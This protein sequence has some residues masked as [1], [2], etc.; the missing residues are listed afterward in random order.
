M[1]FH[2]GFISNIGANTNDFGVEFDRNDK[3]AVIDEM[4]INVVQKL[5]SADSGHTENEFENM[6][7]YATFFPHSVNEVS[8]TSEALSKRNHNRHDDGWRTLE[9]ISNQTDYSCNPKS[10]VNSS[11]T[12]KIYSEDE[13]LNGTI[14]LTGP[15]YSESELLDYTD[16]PNESEAAENIALC[17]QNKTI[18]IERDANGNG[19]DNISYV[20]GNIIDLFKMGIDQT[21]VSEQ[22]EQSSDSVLQLRTDSQ[23]SSES[24]SSSAPQT[25]VAPLASPIPF[26]VPH[27]E[28]DP[29]FSLNYFYDR[30]VRLKYE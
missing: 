24:S 16:N 11:E 22:D 9:E 19:C 26:A 23:T 28:N 27:N 5:N 1:Y 3:S 15:L 25:T 12:T 2:S 8:S 29:E 6:S 7:G 17:T 10:I 14:S 20:D 21:E 18:N 30:G 13:L 4:K